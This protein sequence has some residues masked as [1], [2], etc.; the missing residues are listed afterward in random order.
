[1]VVLQE[2]VITES[3]MNLILIYASYDTT[4]KH[5]SIPLQ[6]TNKEN[7]EEFKQKN[8]RLENYV[9]NITTRKNPDSTS[10]IYLTDAKVLQ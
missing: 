7:M 1:M 10:V 9:R 5:N 8:V 3:S 4:R 2:K 6:E